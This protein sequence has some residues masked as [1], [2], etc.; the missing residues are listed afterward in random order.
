MDQRQILCLERGSGFVCGVLMESFEKIEMPGFPVV[1]K[2]PCVLLASV[3]MSPCQ[4]GLPWQLCTKTDLPLSLSFCLALASNGDLPPLCIFACSLS[5]G[6]ESVRTEAS[7]FLFPFLS[8]FWRCWVF[9]AA[10]QLPLA[11]GWEQRLVCF[12]SVFLSFLAVL[13]LRCCMA[14]SS[15]C[16][17][18]AS[19]CGVLLWS[20]GS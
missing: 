9:V 6:Q 16:G 19:R 17:V 14:A 4:R 7:L 8:H 12:V 15:S 13:G 3:Q 18:W 1:V 11:V 2:L 10:W 5:D 20:L